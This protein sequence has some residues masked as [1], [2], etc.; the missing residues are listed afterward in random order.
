MRKRQDS[1]CRCNE[2]RPSEQEQ[3]DEPYLILTTWATSESSVRVHVYAKGRTNVGA[4][5]RKERKCVQGKEM[6]RGNQMEG[7]KK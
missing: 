3:P 1:S 7:R 4:K 6:K 2:K 5:E